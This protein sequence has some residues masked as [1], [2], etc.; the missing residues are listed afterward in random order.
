MSSA[1]WEWMDFT[2]DL[3]FGVGIG[4]VQHAAVN[5]VL[6]TKTC[7]SDIFIIRMLIF[8]LLWILEGHCQYLT[9]A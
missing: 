4:L 3:N 5:I 1:L 6:E 2:V 7:F 8:Q 9:R